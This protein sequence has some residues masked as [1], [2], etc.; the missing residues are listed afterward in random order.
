M[1]HRAHIQISPVRRNIELPS[2]RIRPAAVKTSQHWKLLDD[3]IQIQIV[4]SI[5]AIQDLQAARGPIQD[6][7]CA[8]IPLRPSVSIMHR[9]NILIDQYAGIFEPDNIKLYMFLFCQLN[10]L[11]CQRFLIAGP[12]RY[13]MTHGLFHFPGSSFYTVRDPV[14]PAPGDDRLQAITFFKGIIAV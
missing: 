10:E 13:L 1:I 11:F 4:I 12:K 3:S 8:C 7:Y 14:F 6:L 2:V 9:Q 5:I